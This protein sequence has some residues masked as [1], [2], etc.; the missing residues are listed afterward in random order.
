ML[1]EQ[2]ERFGLAALH[3][4][5]GRVG[6]GKEASSCLLVHSPGLNEGEK[7]RLLVL[8]DSEDGFVI[9]EEDLKSRGGGDALGARQAGL[10]GG[11]LFDPRED[12]EE[13]SR[14]V[15]IA[16]RDAE[17]LLTR[18]ADLTSARGEAAQLLLKLFGHDLSLAP[19]D[20]G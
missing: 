7:R 18:D 20:A 1:I 3:Q 6:R 17:A 2:A 8:R 10:P 16:H 4:L 11:R 15:Q 12:P 5:R 14:L 9:A 19:L 13:F